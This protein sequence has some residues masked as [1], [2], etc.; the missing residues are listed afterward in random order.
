LNCS[1]WKIE[2][3][4]EFPRKSG[5]P[6]PRISFENYQ[7]R[8]FHFLMLSTELAMAGQWEIV[9]IASV[10]IGSAS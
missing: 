10:S 6:R 1:V 7:P 4:H 2:N 8:F 5:N 3:F 9:I